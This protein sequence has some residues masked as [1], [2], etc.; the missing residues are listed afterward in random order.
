M[1]AAIEGMSALQLAYAVG[2]LAAHRHVLDAEPIAVVGMA[3]RFP[4]GANDH[5][6]FEQ[7]LMEGRDAVREVPA[8]R[9]DVDRLYDPNPK[10][11]GKMYC[12]HGGFLDEIGYFDCGYFGLSPREVSSMDPQHRLLLE[13]AWEAILDARLDP[14]DC[15]GS[16]TG[17]F[18]GLSTFD[19]AEHRIANSSRSHIDPYFVSGSV[20]SA[21]AGRLSYLMGLT[22]P[23]FVVDTACSS[24]LVA[25]HQACSALRRGE[26][27]S[28]LA[29]GVGL[30]MA[31]EPQIA[32][33]KAGM[34]PE[35]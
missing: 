11:P 16:Q 22:G 7:L 25:V 9:W 31:P 5:R 8:D 17:V 32:F 19:F 24:S 23:S 6:A 21:A 20:L 10:A 28:A 26:C 2:K 1:S 34:L 14:K 18:M 4:G 29:G 13:V 12:R 33:C 35:L 30:M 27:D 3:C 15:Y